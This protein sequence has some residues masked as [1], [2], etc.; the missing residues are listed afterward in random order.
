MVCPCRERQ[1]RVALWAG[2]GQKMA[3]PGVTGIGPAAFFA[4]PRFQ[5]SASHHPTHPSLPTPHAIPCGARESD[6]SSGASVQVSFSR[7]G[8]PWIPASRR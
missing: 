7:D 6:G 3:P 2:A 5:F 4:V 1:E 8:L